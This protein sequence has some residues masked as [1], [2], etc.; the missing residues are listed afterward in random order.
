M[1]AEPKVHQIGPRA[2]AELEAGEAGDGKRAE[3]TGRRVAQ[4]F[5]EQHRGL[6]LT[7]RRAAHPRAAGSAKLVF[8]LDGQDE[9]TIEVE[10]RLVLGEEVEVLTPGSPGRVRQS[11]G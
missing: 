9:L 10:H 5:A 11:I 8:H 4:P 3:P 6:R 2:L 1:Q 7:L